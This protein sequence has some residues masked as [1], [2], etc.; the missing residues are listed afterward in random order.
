VPDLMTTGCLLECTMGLTPA[1][2]KA[3]ELPGAPKELGMTAATIVQIIPGHNIPI[4]GMCMSPMNPT[5]ASLT[6]AAQGVLTPGP[7]TPLPVAPW[8][9]PSLTTNHF[10]IPLAVIDSKLACS[11]GGMIQAKKLVPGTAKAT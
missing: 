5:T 6:T 7:C 9:P 11:Y 8:A 2:F 4:F 10:G 1:P 3:D